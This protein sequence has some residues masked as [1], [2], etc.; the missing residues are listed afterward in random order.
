MILFVVY[1]T[2]LLHLERKN[3]KETTNLTNLYIFSDIG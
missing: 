2:I 1:T 3:S